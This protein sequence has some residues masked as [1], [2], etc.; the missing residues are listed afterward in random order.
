MY[1]GAP[2]ALPVAMMLA[3][4]AIDPAANP[5]WLED[6]EPSG[7]FQPLLRGPELSSSAAE[8]AVELRPEMHEAA[9][10]VVIWPFLGGLAPST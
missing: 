9:T 8:A 7:L 4:A 2:I 5:A 3:A 10:P 1:R 6:L